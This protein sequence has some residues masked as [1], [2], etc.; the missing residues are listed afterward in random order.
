MRH[1]IL[2]PVKLAA[3]RPDPLAL[4]AVYDERFQGF[5]AAAS[6]KAAGKLNAMLARAKVKRPAPGL[7]HDLENAA[8]IV[9]A[10]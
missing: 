8:L 2:E 3:P 6:M 5:L 9:D 7:G 1:F 10:G 4:P